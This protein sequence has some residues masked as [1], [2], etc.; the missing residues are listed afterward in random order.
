[1][2]GRLTPVL[3]TYSQRGM[4]T[5]IDVWTTYYHLDDL[6]RAIVAW[7]YRVHLWQSNIDPLHATYL[8]ICVMQYFGSVHVYS[9]RVWMPMQGVTPLAPHKAGP[10]ISPAHAWRGADSRKTT[11]N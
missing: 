1:M 4:T 8:I 5:T 2:F 11:L 3:T 10:V 6:D 7:I 9:T